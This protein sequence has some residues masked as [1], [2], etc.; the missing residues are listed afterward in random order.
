[1]L[2]REIL[3][4]LLG[5]SLGTE[6]DAASEAGGKS[7]VKPTRPRART[8]DFLE[9]TETPL[10]EPAV[11]PAPAGPAA[12]QPPP[13]VTPDEEPPISAAPEPDTP[14]QAK[15]PSPLVRQFAAGL[16]DLS[17]YCADTA[18][19][20]DWEFMAKVTQLCESL[21]ET[22]SARGALKEEAD[23]VGRGIEDAFIALSLMQLEQ[24]EQPCRDAATVLLQLARDLAWANAG[25]SAEAA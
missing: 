23:W 15:T 10:G 1:V 4:R 14:A 5:T 17:A 22:T 3:V 7:L 12:Q 6:G 16:D 21:S 8:R 11:R 20:K 25:N 18:G 24:G 9:F 13:P 2:A 19:F